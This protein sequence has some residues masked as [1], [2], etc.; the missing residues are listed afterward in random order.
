MNACLSLAC[1]PGLD[2]ARVPELLAR[3]HAEPLA[4]PLSTAHVQLVPQITGLL[5]EAHVDLLRAAFPSTRFR[6]HANVRVLPPHRMA[7]LSTFGS[8]D[9]WFRQAARIN[10]QLDAP[11]YS[12]HAGRRRHATLAQVLDNAQRC[13]GLFGCPVAIEGLYPDRQDTQL[14]STWDE[15][16]TVMDSG[17]PYALDLSHLNIVA[18]RYGREDGLVADLLACERCIE[19][20]VSD[21][22]G[23]H[24]SH[25]VCTAPPWWFSLLARLNLEAVVFSEGNH[26]RP[27]PS[28]PGAMNDRHPAQ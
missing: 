19:V 28:Q 3:P 6:L 14:V 23:H 26:K 7:D 9:D 16:R 18:H 25:G 24:D 15:Y 12:A 20:H 27:Q 22:D 1:W 2:Y 21:N 8:D 13:A 10:R 17:V 4:G 5:D 11:A